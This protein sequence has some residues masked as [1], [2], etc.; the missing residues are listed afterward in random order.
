MGGLLAENNSLKSDL[1]QLQQELK[2][3]KSQ[4]ASS[5]L[6][7]PLA[8]RA[9]TSMT[10]TEAAQMATE[11]LESRRLMVSY[12]QQSQS[13]PQSTGLRTDLEEYRLDLLKR[14]KVTLAQ[15]LEVNRPSGIF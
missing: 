3:I 11:L 13:S 5:G 12:D 9:L 7:A 2:T 15:E 6:Q 14:S 10:S 1:T 4:W 8:G